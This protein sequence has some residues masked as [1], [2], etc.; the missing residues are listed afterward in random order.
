MAKLTDE[1]QAQLEALQARAAE[2]EENSDD[3][4]EVT[5]EENGR[6]IRL[7]Y[8]RAKAMLKRMGLDLEDIA[9]TEPPADPPVEKQ[10]SKTPPKPPAK[11]PAKTDPPEPPPAPTGKGYFRK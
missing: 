2:A 9:E 5:I 7:P 8:S 1:E 10:D 6:A 11:P 4:W 3:D